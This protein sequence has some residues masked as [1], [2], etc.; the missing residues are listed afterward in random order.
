MGD[1]KIVIHRL[2][3]LTVHEQRRQVHLYKLQ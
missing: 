2:K 3:K 1:M